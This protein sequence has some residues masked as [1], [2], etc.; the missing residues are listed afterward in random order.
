MIFDNEHLKLLF[1]FMNSELEVQQAGHDGHGR[2]FLHG[3]SHFME[4]FPVGFPIDINETVQIQ[5][6]RKVVVISW[7]FCSA[8]QP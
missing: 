1:E 5:G 2:G 3:F 7:G 4:G 8:L 6:D